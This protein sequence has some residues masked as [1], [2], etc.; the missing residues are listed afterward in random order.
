MKTKIFIYFT[1]ILNLFKLSLEQGSTHKTYKEL[2][3]EDYVSYTI[4]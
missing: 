3:L 1:F 2:E 4:I